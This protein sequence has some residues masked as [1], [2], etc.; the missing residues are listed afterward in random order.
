MRNE[1]EVACSCSCGS[2]CGAGDART[3]LER[4]GGDWV[5]FLY[6]D[7]G[8]G[9]GGGGDSLTCFSFDL[10]SLSVGG[11]CMR[12]FCLLLSLWLL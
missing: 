5:D 7:D 8:D 9:A 11:V 3:G 1:G 12:F 4:L 2:G 10:I 6:N